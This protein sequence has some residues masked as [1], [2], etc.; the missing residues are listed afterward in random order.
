[1]KKQYLTQVIISEHR[2]TAIPMWAG[3][4]TYAH[5]IPTMPIQTYLSQRI[6]TSDDLYLSDDL[7]QYINKL[8]GTTQHVKRRKW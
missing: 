7:K 6:S 8:T 2:T 1:M 3:Y 4:G 5:K